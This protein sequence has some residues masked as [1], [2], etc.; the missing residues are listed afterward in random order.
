MEYADFVG[1]VVTIAKGYRVFHLGRSEING[2][3]AAPTQDLRRR[4]REEHVG[5]HVQDVLDRP[6]AQA[7]R[8]QHP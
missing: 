6:Q 7:N 8:I 5:G 3:G 1:P 4:L 2:S